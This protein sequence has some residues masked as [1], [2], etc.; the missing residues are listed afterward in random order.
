MFW[1][2]LGPYSSCNHLSSE[3][4]EAETE[5]NSLMPTHSW[6]PSQTQNPAISVPAPRF[7]HSVTSVTGVSWSENKSPS[8]SPIWHRGD[9]WASCK[10]Y[11]LCSLERISP[12]QLPA[13]VGHIFGCTGHSET[14]KMVFRVTD[15]ASTPAVCAGD[16]WI[17][18]EK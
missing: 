11:A 13:D 8:E 15:L 4:A 14:A 3:E 2:G 17:F 18:D 1:T 12:V 5:Q 9:V 10:A 7:S 6:W 16:N